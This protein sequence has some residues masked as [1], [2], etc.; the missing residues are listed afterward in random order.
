MPINNSTSKM[1]LRTTM[2]TYKLNVLPF[3]RICWWSLFAHEFRS[4]RSV[5]IQRQ[6]GTGP[7]RHERDG[8]GEVRGCY[9]Y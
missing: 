1:T 4:G 3:T 9:C 8:R 6:R 5:T 2:V 7:R